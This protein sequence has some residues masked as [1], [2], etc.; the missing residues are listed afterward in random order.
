MIF[1]IDAHTFIW[2]LK[3]KCDEGDE[4]LR[5]RAIH[6]FK[7]IDDNKHQVM[8]PTVVL[9]EVLSVEPLE[10]YAV[11]MD[12]I[13]KNFI[14]ADFDQRSSMK[15][16]Q[17]FMNKIEELKKL[18]QENEISRQKMK[19]DHLIVACAIVGGAN[20]IY[21]HDKGLKAFGQKYIEVK[22]LP[23]LPPPQAIQ[24]GIFDD[25]NRKEYDTSIEK[26]NTQKEGDKI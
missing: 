20:C 10:N 11:I 14:V 8:L 21:S 24:T 12:K 19:V 5:D 7:F 26:E 16:A 22:D 2:G 9:G 15:Y 4:H 23:P 17:L 6:L 13:G 25:L 1:C 3:Q 18:S